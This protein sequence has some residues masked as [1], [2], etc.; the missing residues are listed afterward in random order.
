MNLRLTATPFYISVDNP[1]D[2][3]PGAPVINNVNLMVSDNIELDELIM[4]LALIALL[5]DLSTDGGRYDVLSIDDL[6][7]HVLSIDL[8]STVGLSIY[9]QG[10]E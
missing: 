3:V 10:A 2:E 7:P 5:F 8:L 9:A 4:V 1:L 6:S